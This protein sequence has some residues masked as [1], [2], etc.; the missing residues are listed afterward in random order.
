M[1]GEPAPRTLFSPFELNYVNEEATEALRREAVRKVLPVYTVQFQTLSSVPEKV[2]QIVGIVHDYRVR[3]TEDSTLT[4]A[5]LSLPIEIPSEVQTFLIEGADLEEMRKQIAVLFETGLPSL[6]FGDALKN[7]LIQKGIQEITVLGKEIPEKIHLTKEVP[8]L[9][10]VKA[11]A[12]DI[13][14]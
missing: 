5:S 14:K 13:L 10:E 8:S 7:E 12:A 9:Q 1:L 4:G 11:K 2:D 3:K 6:I